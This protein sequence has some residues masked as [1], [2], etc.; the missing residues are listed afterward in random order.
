MCH[1]KAHAVHVYRIEQG[2]RGYNAGVR[3]KQLSYLPYTRFAVEM[4]YQKFM[5]RP[6]T[7]VMKLHNSLSSVAKLMKLVQRTDNHK[8]HHTSV[9][10]YKCQSSRSKKEKPDPSGYFKP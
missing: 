2:E 9:M 10:K 3:V 7:E 5:K 8:H 6:V 4:H 1:T